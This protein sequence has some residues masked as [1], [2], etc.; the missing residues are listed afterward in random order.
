MGWGD[1][2]GIISST[3]WLFERLGTNLW[4]W[5]GFS[6]RLE[7]GANC[8]ILSSLFSLMAFTI[9]ILYY[10]QTYW[11]RYMG[12]SRSSYGGRLSS[13]EPR[14]SHEFLVSFVYINFDFSS[15]C[16]NKNGRPIFFLFYVKAVESLDL[17]VPFPLGLCVLLCIFFCLS[18]L[19]AIRKGKCNLAV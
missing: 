19:L 14:R 8:S 6:V 2:G 11:R 4:E 12:Y 7:W 9:P 16:W 18:F 5:I 15:C 1:K 3:I 17:L 13:C 10:K